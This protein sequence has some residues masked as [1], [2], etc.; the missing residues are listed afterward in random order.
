MLQSLIVSGDMY[1]FLYLGLC[2]GIFKVP[3]PSDLAVKGQYRIHT[4]EKGL[5]VLLCIFHEGTIECLYFGSIGLS[6]SKVLGVFVLMY[7]V[8]V[9]WEYFAWEFFQWVE[10][11][12]ECSVLV[13]QCSCL[14]TLGDTRL[15]GLVKQE[16]T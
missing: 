16:W 9:L 10:V 14:Q 12:G 11:G 13:L 2:L 1:Q 5:V 7:L 15:P 8:F 4:V 6:C 3:F